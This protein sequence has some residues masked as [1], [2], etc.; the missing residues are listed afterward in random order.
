MVKKPSVCANKSQSA[1]RL[2]AA[3][4]FIDVRA[5][6]NESRSLLEKSAF[7]IDALFNCATLVSP[8]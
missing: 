3:A 4:R 5:S 6:T 8:C 1:L 2:I 7:E